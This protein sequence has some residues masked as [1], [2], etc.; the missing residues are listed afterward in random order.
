MPANRPVETN[1]EHE[2]RMDADY[3][4]GLILA[5]EWTKVR[6]WI[7]RRFPP[8]HEA[9]AVGLIEQLLEVGPGARVRDD[10]RAFLAK[11]KT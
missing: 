5:A 2:R 7:D 3:V 10:A 4:S 6:E 1:A 8:K 11:H 9:E